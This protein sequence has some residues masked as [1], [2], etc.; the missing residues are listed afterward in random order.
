MTVSMNVS[1]NIRDDWREGL[2]K[3]GYEVIPSE[4]LTEATVVIS[5]TDGDLGID[6]ARLI[7]VSGDTGPEKIIALVAARVER[8]SDWKS[9]SD[10]FDPLTGLP[11]RESVLARLENEIELST[12]IM[13]P[14][15]IAI[16]EPDGYE[17]IAAGL[18]QQAGDKAFREFSQFL[19]THFRRIDGVGRWGTQELAI[20]MPATYPSAAMAAIARIQ[21]VL[22]GQGASA[23]SITSFSAG[24]SAYPVD[25]NDRDALIVMAEER[26]ADARRKGDGRVVMG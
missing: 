22:S 4:H 19:S 15:A 3:A 25:A 1:G 17:A 18:G 10:G 11:V 6:E 20:V 24:V 12:R 5:D 14:F 16:I 21:G 2:E 13:K 7:R 9:A 8:L 26:L 23:D